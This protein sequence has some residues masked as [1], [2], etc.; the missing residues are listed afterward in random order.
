MQVT[1]S[2]LEE[3][4]TPAFPAGAVQQPGQGQGQG[5]V[6]TQQRDSNVISSGGAGAGGSI[7]VGRFAGMGMSVGA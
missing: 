1:Y 3:K 5:G 6:P 7:P 4:T 2:D